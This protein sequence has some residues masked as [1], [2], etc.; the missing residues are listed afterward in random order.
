MYGK[1]RSGWDI[2]LLGRARAGQIHDDHQAV[3]LD[4]DVISRPILQPGPRVI[5][6]DLH[7]I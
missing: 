6:C 7:S 3:R 1:Q 5:Y 2:V 4:I